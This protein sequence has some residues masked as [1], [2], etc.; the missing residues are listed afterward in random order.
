MVLEKTF[1]S[2]LECKEIQPVNPKGNKSGIFIGRTDAE[3]EAPIFWAPNVKNSLIGKAPD[4]GKDWR[5]VG[6]ATTED[7]MND[8]IPNSMGM[9]LNKL[10]EMVKHK[11]ALVCFSPWHHK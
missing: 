2:P 7:E 3:V 11:E 4:A 9:T 6:K 10:W 1:E 5:Q 8:G